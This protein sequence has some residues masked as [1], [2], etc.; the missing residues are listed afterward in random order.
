M[1]STK[2]CAENNVKYLFMIAARVKSIMESTEKLCGGKVKLK[3]IKVLLLVEVVNW[4]LYCMY[5][6]KTRIFTDI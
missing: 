2:H 5:S 1:F 6:A 3:V 4:D